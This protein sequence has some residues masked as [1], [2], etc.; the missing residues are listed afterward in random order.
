VVTLWHEFPKTNVTSRRRQRG[1]PLIPDSLES[2]LVRRQAA[3]EGPASGTPSSA[4][5]IRLSTLF[6]K[7]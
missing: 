1:W 6:S 3:D 2:A 7:S 4:C 5:S